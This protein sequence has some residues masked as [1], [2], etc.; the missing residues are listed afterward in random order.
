MPA[1]DLLEKGWRNLIMLFIGLVS[2]NGNGILLHV[3]NKPVKRPALFSVVPEIF[4]LQAL[5]IQ[6]AN[7]KPYQSIRH[8]AGFCHIDQ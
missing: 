8:K 4:F 2:L 5:S 7:A 3:R 6:S 1:E